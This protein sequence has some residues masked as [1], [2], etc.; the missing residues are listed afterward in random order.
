[1][2]RSSSSTRLPTVLSRG[3][4]RALLA[5]MRGTHRLIALLLYGAR[6]RLMECLTL[7]VKD[8]DGARREICVKAPAALRCRR[9]LTGRHRRGPQI[10]RGNGCFLR[11]G[12][13][14]TA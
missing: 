2:L 8:V 3:D 13:I 6:L 10:S 4:V 11:R 9:P 12:A 5:H 14:G 1:M 7:R